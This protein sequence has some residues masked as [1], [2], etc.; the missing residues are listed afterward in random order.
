MPEGRDG[1][2]TDEE[3]C[4]VCKGTRVVERRTCAPSCRLRHAEECPVVRKVACAM[5]EKRELGEDLNA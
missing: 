1:V 3:V 4:P 2:V 5:C